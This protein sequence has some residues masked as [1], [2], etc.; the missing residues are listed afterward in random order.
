MDKKRSIYPV[1]L[2]A[3][4][5]SPLFFLWYIKDFFGDINF[6]PLNLSVRY[7]YLV[8]ISCTF[9]T[10]LLYLFLEKKHKVTPLDFKHKLI[11]IACA[12]ALLSFVPNIFSIDFNAYIMWARVWTI[13]HANPYYVA[14]VNFPA[15]PFMKGLFWIHNPTSYGPLWTLLSGMTTYIAGDSRLINFL[16]LKLVIYV[17]YMFFLIMT[18]LLLRLRRIMNSDLVDSFIMFNPYFIIFFLIDGHLDILMSALVLASVYLLYKNKNMLSAIFFALSI[19]TKYMTAMLAPLFLIYI[20]F[21]SKSF[22]RGL[23]SVL[24]YS[25]ISVAV[26]LLAYLPFWQGWDIFSLPLRHKIGMGINSNTLPYALVLFIKRLFNL[27][28]VI[29]SQ[30]PA[31]IINIFRTFFLFFYVLIIRYFIVSKKNLTNFANASFFIFLSYF[32]FESYQFEP[33]YIIWIMPF[34]LLSNIKNKLYLASAVSYACIISFWK[35]LSFL[36]FIVIFIYLV[37][38]MFKIVIKKLQVLYAK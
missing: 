8:I 25:F 21:N 19:L 9:F 18:C 29:P 2:Y 4:S 35:R 32:M 6:P 17:G 10:F 20:I 12:G 11:I 26:I 15:D 31:M 36:L 1:L 30:P 22:K 24:S 16:F 33:W 28:H 13:H 3:L 23:L 27:N 5:L 7:I 34:L 38:I 37:Y 14:P